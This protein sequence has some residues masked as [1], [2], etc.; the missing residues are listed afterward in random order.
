MSEEEFDGKRRYGLADGREERK[1]ASQ[2]CVQHKVIARFLS[3]RDAL[4]CMS[5]RRKQQST[6]SAVGMCQ[7]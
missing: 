3:P 7:L 4:W 6:V 1:Q 5:R 2:F